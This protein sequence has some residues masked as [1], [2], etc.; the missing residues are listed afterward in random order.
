VTGGLGKGAHT[1][2]TGRIA[3]NRAAVSSS[4]CWDA[5][6]VGNREQSPDPAVV[7]DDCE[8]PKTECGASRTLGA[9]G[10]L[11]VPPA[12]TRPP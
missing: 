2:A 11:V 7:S 12:Q 3:S 10:G 1:K 4:R 5:N 9:S 6:M 8:P